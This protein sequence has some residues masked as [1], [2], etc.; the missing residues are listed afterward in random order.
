M[1]IQPKQGTRNVNDLF[2][3]HEAKRIAKLNDLFGNVELTNNEEKALIWLA[4]LD[5]WT[6]DNIISAVKKAIDM[7]EQKSIHKKLETNRLKVKSRNEDRNAKQREHSQ[8]ER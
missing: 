7:N 6:V 5:D 3:Q 2:Y 4:G 8:E 1:I